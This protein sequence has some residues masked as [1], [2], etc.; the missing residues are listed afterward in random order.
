MMQMIR[1]TGVNIAVE[2]I[3]CAIS[4]K[5]CAGRAFMDRVCMRQL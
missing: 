4:N 2:H 1:L 3:C 5:K